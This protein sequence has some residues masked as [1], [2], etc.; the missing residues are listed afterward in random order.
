[1]TASKLALLQVNFLS[2]FPE[3]N[4]YYFHTCVSFLFIIFLTELPSVPYLPVA[5]LLPVTTLT[6]I[7][8]IPLDLCFLKEN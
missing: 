3:L 4:Y 5:T 1:M 7:L 2:K 6:H 8:H